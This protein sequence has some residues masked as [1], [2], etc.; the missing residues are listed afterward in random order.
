MSLH[1]YYDPQEFRRGDIEQLAAYYETLLREAIKGP[2]SLAAD[3]AMLDEAGLR[4][5]VTGFNEAVGDRAA[6]ETLHGLF[7]RLVDKVPERIAVTFKDEHITYRELNKRANRLARYLQGLGAASEQ[8][9]GVCIERSLEMIVAVLGILKAG[10][11][12][13][14]IDPSSPVERLKLIIDDANLS[15]LLTLTPFDTSPLKEGLDVVCITSD[16]ARISEQ[17]DRDPVADVAD[18]NLAYVIYTSGSTGRPKGVM[19]QHRSV[20]NLIEA[21]KE[22]VYSQQGGSLQIGLSAPLAFDASVKQLIQL[23]EGHTLHILPEE[24]RL[25]GQSFRAYTASREIEALDST[26]SQLSLVIRTAIEPSQESMD[27]FSM[28]GLMLLGGESLD[29][30]LWHVLEN[31]PR[32]TYVNVYGPTECTVDATA[33]RI[34]P[35]TEPGTIGRPLRNTRT[36]LLDR[37]FK[38][39]AIGEPGE[40]F[41]G[42][43]GLA[44][45]YLNRPDLTAEKFLPDC[46]VKRPGERMYST[47]DLACYTRD[48]NI[49]LIGRRDHQVKLRGYRIELGEIE[50]IL[51]QH[52]LIRDAVVTVRED[53]PG[54]KCLV[55]YIISKNRQSPPIDDMRIF[56]RKRLP[57]YMMPRV[58]LP[59]SE[60]PLSRNGKIDRRT[61]PPPERIRPEP[62]TEFVA[63][64]GEIEQ[65]IAAIWKDVLSL[66]K[67][68]VN[69]NFFDLG[70]HSLLL[71]QLH[72]KLRE[73]LRKDVPM[74]ELF[75]NPTV[76]L[77]ARYFSQGER[78]DE[79]LKNEVRRASVR[80]DAIDRKARLARERRRLHE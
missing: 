75:R 56:L 21:L 30:Q 74:V 51:R 65:A 68:G 80:R 27:G 22:S 38:L 57:D 13:L 76:S 39:V 17:S 5:L 46:F 10:A 41:I 44:R 79:S 67:I 23:A 25:D 54:G 11:A 35:G 28:P 42:G 37:R 61:L 14:P 53:T 47:G 19:I 8:V 24:V 52:P 18:L 71:V 12:Y 60:F 55:A 7:E 43:E 15:L 40:L 3:L 33:F 59:L 72:N 70:G 2:G 16:W 63:P 32:S 20:M 69:D 26:P 73:T 6:C 45:G 9:I 4:Q 1:F 49:K 78:R 66:E 62:S 77:Q 34:Q 58:I 64:S 48:L 29:Q 36:Y 31:D 50:S